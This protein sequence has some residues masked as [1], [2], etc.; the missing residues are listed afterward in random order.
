MTRRELLQLS[1]A[2]ALPVGSHPRLAAQPTPNDAIHKYLAAEVERISKTFLDGA[3]SKDEW[4]KKRP[5]L[6]KQFLD[7]LG[8]DPLPEKTPLKATTT[9]T[10]TRG[11]V[12]VENVHFQSR[13]GLYVTG[14]L[15]RPKASAGKLPGILYVC[16][17][18]GRGRD[19]NKTAFQDH[20]QW[21]A[22]N[23]YVCLVVDTLQLGEVAGKD[24]K[25]VV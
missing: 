23:G 19:G 6:Q 12:T 17:H 5:A 21:F 1:A 7:M 15:Y 24:R 18:S 16:G 3:K 10:L 8:L 9:G 22:S 14:N 20:G 2:C 13:P 4:A 25:S 11:D